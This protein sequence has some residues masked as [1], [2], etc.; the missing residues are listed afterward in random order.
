VQGDE[1][2]LA[3]LRKA[4]AKK[5]LEGLK[6]GLQAGEPEAL[7]KGRSRA[8]ALLE[9]LKADAHSKTDACGWH[10]VR[11]ELQSMAEHR[12]LAFAQVA[13]ACR[14]AVVKGLT[15]SRIDVDVSRGARP[16]EDRAEQHER[17]VCL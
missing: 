13:L 2:K 9:K 11:I 10:Q 12:D 4:T 15:L 1:K 8:F 17:V 5:D 3:V 16:L 6:A 7:A 14:R